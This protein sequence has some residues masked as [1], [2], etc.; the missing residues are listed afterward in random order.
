M[1]KQIYYIME[2]FEDIYYLEVKRFFELMHLYGK[3]G[4]I[5]MSKF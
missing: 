5:K 1:R 2:N 4:R 3:T